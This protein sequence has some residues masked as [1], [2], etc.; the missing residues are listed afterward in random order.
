MRKTLT[1]TWRLCAGGP[2]G[3]PCTGTTSGRKS[4]AVAA[5][6]F[7]V[8]ARAWSASRRVVSGARRLMRAGGGVEQ[9]A[10]LR[11]EPAGRLALPLPRTALA[12]LPADSCPPPEASCEEAWALKASGGR[13]WRVCA[14]VFIGQ[15]SAS[16]PSVRQQAGTSSAARPAPR[17]AACGQTAAASAW[18]QPL[19]KRA[20]RTTKS[21][22]RCR[23]NSDCLENAD[24][25]SAR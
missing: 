4:A 20:D 22:R 5:L 10:Q 1:R 15:C 23:I 3:A 18:P 19:R 8:L 13:A 11:H 21:E 17:S 9:P 12:G 24:G 2:G 14:S 16:P 25:R 7:C 6:N